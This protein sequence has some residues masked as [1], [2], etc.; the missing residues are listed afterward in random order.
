MSLNHL[1][2]EMNGEGVALY[3]LPLTCF[4]ILASGEFALFRSC[5]CIPLQHCV[6]SYEKILQIPNKNPKPLIKHCVLCTGHKEGHCSTEDWGIPWSFHHLE[7]HPPTLWTDL[8]LSSAPA[9]LSSS[10]LTSKITSKIHILL[11]SP[12]EQLGSL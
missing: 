8:P 1:L 6:I 3:I 5:F 4:W 9:C 7:I 11:S 10:S 12:A 2:H